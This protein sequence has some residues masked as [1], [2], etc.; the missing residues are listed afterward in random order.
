M[1]KS[2]EVFMDMREEP[3]VDYIPVKKSIYN[4]QFDYLRLMEEIEANEGELTPETEAQLTINRDELEEK[5]VS[6]GYVIKQFDF[7]IEQIKAEMERLSKISAAKEKIQLGLKVRIS[8][9]MMGFKIFKV[10]KN[11]LTLSFHKSEQLIIDEGASIPVDYIKTK[12]VEIIDK[13]GLKA[14]I[15]SGQE[16]LGIFIHENQN[17]QIK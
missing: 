1:S 12:E 4:I 2:K 7:E 10:Q 5:V 16:F 8:E 6:Y 9:A 15:K 13:A 3:S 14:A 17:L 11:N